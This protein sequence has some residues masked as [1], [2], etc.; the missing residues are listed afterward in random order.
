MVATNIYA[1]LITRQVIDAVGNSLADAILWKIVDKRFFGATHRLPFTPNVAE[2]AHKLLFLRVHRQYGLI[3]LHELIGLCINILEL[4]VPIWM[5]GSLSVLLHR[6]QAVSKLGAD[7]FGPG[8][9][10]V[11]PVT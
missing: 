3:P 9:I 1:T 5:V 11:D 10:T 6:L 7:L 8:R 2:I 4:F